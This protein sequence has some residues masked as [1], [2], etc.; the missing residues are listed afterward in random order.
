MEAGDGR[1]ELNADQARR[2]LQRGLVEDGRC[3]AS[4]EQVTSDTSLEDDGGRLEVAVLVNVA[5]RVAKEKS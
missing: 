3:D 1:S 5:W 4:L 2:K